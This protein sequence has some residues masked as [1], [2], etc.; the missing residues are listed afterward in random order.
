[1]LDLGELEMV[2]DDLAERLHAARVRIADVPMSR[3]RNGCCWSGCCWIRL[4]TGSLGS[5]AGSWASPA[6]ASGR[7]ALGWA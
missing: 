7:C 2:R 6:A 3:P 4:P 1:M 5:P